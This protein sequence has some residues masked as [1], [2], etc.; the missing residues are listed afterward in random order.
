MMKKIFQSITISALF[1]LI[2][3][4]VLFGTTDDAEA[5]PAFARKYRISCSTCHVAVPKL[6]DYGEDFAGNGF[7][8]PDG[9]EPKRTYIDTGDDELLLLRELP[10]AVRLDAYIQ[11][12]DRDNVKSDL[13]VPYG[14]KLLSGGP[15]TK[16]I[17]YYFYFYI[18][19]RG[20]VAGIEDAY[21]HFNNIGKTTFDIM[22][23]QFQISDPLF[24][25][26]LRLTFEDYQIYR[27]QPGDSKANL[28][29]DRGIMAIYG[30]DFG[31]DLFGQL[32]NGNGIGPAEDRLFDFDS[33]KTYSLR[34]SQGLGAF[35]LGLFGLTGMEENSSNVK[36]SYWYLGPDA[37][38]ANFNWELNLQYLYRE[39]DNAF[40]RST[41]NQKHQTKG[42]IAELLYFPKGD[43]SKWIFAA[44]YNKIDATSND[45]DYET[46]TLSISHM[47][48]RNFRALAELT[49]DFIKDKPRFTVGFVTAF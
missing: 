28:T 9:E 31:L 5:I 26:E 22:L 16:S 3:L 29:Y 13:Q 35:R 1:T 45:L 19:E 25:R 27:V 4:T 18:S 41:S 10:L 39:D 37:T 48:A 7:L 38:I 36:N 12:A 49:W 11:A 8:L 17:S 20:K 43:R 24:K 34:A 14:L 15:I 23:G 2:I 6:K 44:L 46:G 40:F 30:F 42:G 33:H 21:V 32:V 47:V